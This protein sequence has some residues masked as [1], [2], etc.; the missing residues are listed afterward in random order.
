[1]NYY[2]FFLQKILLTGFMDLQLTLKTDEKSL[3]L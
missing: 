1:M 3:K 2:H